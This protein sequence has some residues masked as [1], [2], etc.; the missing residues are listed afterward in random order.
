MGRVRLWL[1]GL[2]VGL[3]ALLWIAAA[4]GCSR[5]PVQASDDASPPEQLPFDRPADKAGFSPTGLISA[6]GIPAGTPITIRLRSPISSANA[7]PGDCFEA[8]L[9]EPVLVNGQLILTPGTAVHGKILQAESAASPHE[10]GYARLTLTSLTYGDH[11]LPLETATLF[12]KAS[13]IKSIP[14]TQVPYPQPAD[15]EVNL[16]IDH[17]LTFRLTQLVQLPTN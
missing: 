9:D 8:V 16:P 12:L 10:T 14:G 11:S 5:E 15:A 4:V 17:R 7:K 1:R 13:R 3:L 2:A 6:R